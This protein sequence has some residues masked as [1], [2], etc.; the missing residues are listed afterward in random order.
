MN[1]KP[2]N[3]RL[4][5][6]DVFRGIT[7]ALMILVNSPGNATPYYWLE[8]SAWNGCT[9][10]DLVFPFFIVIVGISSVLALTNL[11]GVLCR[12]VRNFPKYTCSL[13]K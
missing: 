12:K 8:H 6:L 1:L 11:K 10:A 9:L 2:V 4:I 5:S 3:Q 13:V 7:I